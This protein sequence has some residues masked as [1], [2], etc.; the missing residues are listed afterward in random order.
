MMYPKISSMRYFLVLLFLV[1][2]MG[3]NVL[4]QGCGP[5]NPNCIVPTA[6]VGT[7]NNQAASTAFVQG[8]VTGIITCPG[9]VPGNLVDSVSSGVLGDAGVPATILSAVPPFKTLCNA[10]GITAP[11]QTCDAITALAPLGISGT[12][13][14][15]D[16]DTTSHNIFVG[17][18]GARL[19]L[20]S[21]SRN[22]G[23]GV[24]TFSGLTTGTGNTGVGA[25]A[26]NSITTGSNNICI[27]NSSGN[28]IAG[29]S[30][31]L[32]V[33]TNSIFSVTSSSANTGIGLNA[34][35]S[36]TGSD[37]TAIGNGAGSTLTGAN[38]NT[39]VGDG[40]GGG[41]TTGS[42]NSI[43][44]RCT[45]LAATLAN[46]V[47][48]C[49]GA[50]TIRYD[51]G[52]TVAATATLAGPVNVAGQLYSTAGLP[53][54]AS[55]AC[56]ATTNGTVGAGSTNQSGFIN[57]GAAATTSCTLSWSATLS[58]APNSCVFFPGNAAA[59]TTGTTVAWAAAPST[60]S[61]V[62]N[63]SALANTV[64]RYMCL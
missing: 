49:D 6:P 48:L 62:L 15:A 4:A 38:N 47:I 2:I 34:L 11:V 44:G 3:G 52:K 23:I 57:I 18:A 13:L 12:I 28:A 53:T 58:V 61:V 8:A 41:I 63:G 30:N 22:V 46:S 26:C 9:C 64:Y 45:G 1:G 50:G 21:A 39:I 19:G 17:T 37:N 10:T 32:G 40:G 33:G 55:G 5:Q 16:A 7:S 27:G 54:I 43:F 51:W 35:I 56:G 20:T 60:A 42:G 36:V 24:N 59:A 29:G 14:N 25:F 31:N